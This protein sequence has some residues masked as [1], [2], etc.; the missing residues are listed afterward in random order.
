MK[1]LKQNKFKTFIYLVII[2]VAVFCGNWLYKGRRVH[3]KDDM[4]RQVICLELGKD[5]D[6]QDVTYRDLETIEELEIGP[7]GSFE[8]I[9]D[10]AKCKNLKKLWVNVSLLPKDA[11]FELYEI[12]ET[13]E[14]YYPPVSKEKM[15]RIQ[16]DLEKILKS[17]KLIEDFDFTNVKNSF[18][19]RDMEFLK[20]GKNIKKID[21]SYSN[22]KDYSVLE[23]CKKL[24]NIDLWY[25]DIDS[26]DDLLKL[27]YVNRLILTGTP[28]AQKEEEI[29]KLQKAF[30]EAEIVVD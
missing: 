10:V 11:S 1:K 14:R 24:R 8:T 9:E 26:A 30:P 25:S 21:I 27:K 7:L 16:K 23:N 17:A 18:D 22:I 3:F 15:E 29:A 4:M 13:G 6:S 19:M 12:T 20:Y 5:K 2:V 28:L